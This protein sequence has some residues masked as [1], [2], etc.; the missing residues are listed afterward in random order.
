[1][2][3]DNQN[4]LITVHEDNY[5]NR[6]KKDGT[7]SYAREF[8]PGNYQF[9]TLQTVMDQFMI[10]YVG[11][12]KI[13]PTINKLDVQ[14][15]AMRGLQ[16]FSY[17][18]LKSYKGFEFT[19]PPKLSVILPQDFVAY[20]QVSWS[21]SNGIKHPIHY[22]NDTSNPR[23][24]YQ[25][26]NDSLHG[27]DNPFSLHAIGTFTAGSSV[28]ELDGLY[29]ELFTSVQ[30]VGG[31]T[32]K[33]INPGMFDGVVVSGGFKGAHVYAVWH[34]KTTQKTSIQINSPNDGHN[35]NN[36][37]IVPSVSGDM[38][39]EFH[40]QNPISIPYDPAKANSYNLIP[41][42]KLPILYNPV[43]SATHNKITA[44]SPADVADIRVGMKVCCSNEYFNNQNCL[45]LDVDYENGF[46]WV[47]GPQQTASH[48]SPLPAGT[49]LIASTVAPTGTT[50]TSIPSLCFVDEDILAKNAQRR[51]HGPHM[52]E[53]S[54]TLTSFKGSNEYDEATDDEIRALGGAKYGLDP[55]RANANGTFYIDQDKGTM[56]FSSDLVGKT[57]II[58]YISDSLGQVREQVVHKFA[59][60]AMYKWIAYAV[61]A[62]RSNTPE[63]LVARFKKE[64]FAEMRKA[65]LRL[66]NINFKEFT[67]I[68]RGKSKLIKH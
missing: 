13:I 15:H 22:T 46:I 21:D 45:V 20:T 23:N 16:E 37:Q 39:L 47:H 33:F 67:Q 38:H 26:E 11:K 41:G 58:D 54:D 19:L 52:Y 35:V 7:G 10:S 25:T 53:E 48:N 65:K 3:W 61:L 17:D 12:D 66:Q 24:P 55:Q 18:T 31:V 51:N 14:F 42:V 9:V 64:R 36:V 44:A 28:V 8:E 68:L 63:Y 30:G 43:F 49:P 1:M 34:D 6:K 4:Q 27:Q 62:T 50:F 56:R 60:E 57:I 32:I 5:Y 29:P 40:Y 2:A 59:E